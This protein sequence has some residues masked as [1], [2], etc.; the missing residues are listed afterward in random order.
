MFSQWLELRVLINIGEVSSEVFFKSF[1]FVLISKNVFRSVLVVAIPGCVV[2]NF[3][4][5]QGQTSPFTYNEPDAD[6]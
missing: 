3:L 5:G 6:K 2:F 1:V 4:S